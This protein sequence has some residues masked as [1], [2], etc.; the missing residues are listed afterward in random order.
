MWKLWDYLTKTVHLPL[1]NGPYVPGGVDVMTEYSSSG[2]SIRLYY[3]SEFVGKGN[4]SPQSFDAFQKRWIPWLPDH[5]Y[6]EG[7]AKLVG[8]WKILVWVTYAI[9]AGVNAKIPVYWG[10]LFSPT[11]HKGNVTNEDGARSFKSKKHPVVIISHGMAGSRFVHSALGLELAS[12]G[13]VVAVVDHRDGS[14]S[15]TYYYKS[16]EM[17][18]KGEK[19]WVPYIN[20]AFGNAKHHEIRKEQVEL[21]S[22]ELIRALNLLE[23]INVGE[24]DDNDNILHADYAGME[25]RISQMKGRLNLTSPAI[26]GFSFGGPSAL[27]AVKKDSRFRRG[28]ALDVWMFPI[29]EKIEEIGQALVASQ[30]SDD[31]KCKLLFINS[32]TFHN[33]IN[34]KAMKTL[35]DVMNGGSNAPHV[36]TIKGTTH[37]YLC[38]WSL[39]LGSWLDMFH[40]G[41][42]LPVH[43]HQLLSILVLQFLSEQYEADDD[44]GLTPELKSDCDDYIQCQMQHLVFDLIQKTKK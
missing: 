16:K 2:T 26:I 33:D 25:F 28:I 21:R 34:L 12:H 23:K 32:E 17:R 44:S 20:V 10:S 9:I 6:F 24:M 36:T 4:K 5:R 35:L 43:G 31:P 8:L 41:K 14:A 30:S 3:P 11:E 22:E 42:L 39:L 27:T 15:G 13:F 29:K 38:D 18:D 40:M 1:P 19:T 37:E 7:C